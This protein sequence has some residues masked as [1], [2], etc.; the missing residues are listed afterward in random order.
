[1]TRTHD[2]VV[3]DYYLASLK[4]LEKN[5]YEKDKCQAFFEAHLLQLY[6]DVP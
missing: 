2:A 4:C 1:M 3:A 6:S 5:N